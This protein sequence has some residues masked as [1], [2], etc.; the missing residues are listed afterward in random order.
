MKEVNMD[1]IRYFMWSAINGILNTC[2][3]S[4]SNAWCEHLL[5]IAKEYDAYT[6]K[7]IGSIADLKEHIDDDS[8]LNSEMS[9]ISDKLFDSFLTIKRNEV[10][11]KCIN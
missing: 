4:Y 11:E 3:N 2:G 9:K 6:G 5:T 8:E 10:G 7:T 1:E